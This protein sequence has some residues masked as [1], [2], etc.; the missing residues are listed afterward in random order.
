M[1]TP[2]TTPGAAAP[3]AIDFPALAAERRAAH[4]AEHQAAARRGA[5]LRK[6]MDVALANAANGIAA[7]VRQ[8]TQRQ[9][10]SKAS[11]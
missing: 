10:G 5:R 11:R 2:S 4:R 7:T 8:L 6:R 1:F 3:I 9:R